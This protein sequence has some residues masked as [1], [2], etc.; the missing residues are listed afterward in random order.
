MPAPARTRTRANQINVHNAAFQEPKCF[1][2]S[3]VVPYNERLMILN[4]AIGEF[5]CVPLHKRERSDQ[6]Q[7]FR[8]SAARDR[9]KR[10]HPYPSQVRGLPQTVAHRHKPTTDKSECMQKARAQASRPGLPRDPGRT[11]LE[12]GPG[13]LRKQLHRVRKMCI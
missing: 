5:R 12:R 1:P 7:N 3:I 8:V 6:H 9:R 13:Q 10:C 11:K 4:L 2:A